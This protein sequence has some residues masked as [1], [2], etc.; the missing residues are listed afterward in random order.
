MKSEE[1]T[2][3]RGQKQPQAAA[4]AKNEH[5]IF[6]EEKSLKLIKTGIHG[7]IKIKK[8]TAGAKRRQHINR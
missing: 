7:Y 4:G 1:K 8:A 3:E 6:N 5:R 2:Y